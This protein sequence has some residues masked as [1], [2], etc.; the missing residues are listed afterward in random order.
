MID[1]TKYLYWLSNDEEANIKEIIWRELYTRIGYNFHVIQMIEYNIANIIS[2]E[3]F[4]KNKKEEFTENDIN[5]IKNLIENKYILLSEYT[6]GQLKN[7][8]EGS[9]YLKEIDMDSLS[10]VVN[11]RN[12]LAHQCFKEKLLNDELEN[13]EDVEKF[14]DELNNFEAILIPLNEYLINVFKENKVKSILVK[15]SKEL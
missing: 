7:E 10:K 2:I 12:Y 1:K 6:F 15:R 13:L 14:I 4:E 8:V 3:E 11:Y 9:S 5:E